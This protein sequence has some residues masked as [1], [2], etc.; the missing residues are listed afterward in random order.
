MK[1]LHSDSLWFTDA[2]YGRITDDTFTNMKARASLMDDISALLIPGETTLRDRVTEKHRLYASNVEKAVA[3]VYG[4]REGIFTILCADASSR[5]RTLGDDF[6]S[7]LELLN[8]VLESWG[9]ARVAQFGFGR[10]EFG[11]GYRFTSTVEGLTIHEAYMVKADPTMLDRLPKKP[12]KR[13]KAPLVPLVPLAAGM[14]TFGTL[15]FNDTRP[16]SVPQE[17]PVVLAHS[18]ELAKVLFPA[19]NNILLGFEEAERLSRRLVNLDRYDV[20]VQSTHDHLRGTPAVRKVDVCVGMVLAYDAARQGT[21]GV[22]FD[23]QFRRVV[24]I[25]PMGTVMVE[26]LYKAYIDGAGHPRRVKPSLVDVQNVWCRRSERERNGEKTKVIQ[27]KH[28]RRFHVFDE[29]HGL[30]DGLIAAQ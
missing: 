8:H 23:W 28:W 25:T 10:R 19:V 18:H 1:D 26:A 22:L 2:T 20:R 30:Y 17:C 4:A 14:S 5:I 7:H 6:E 21:L 24:R 29:A 15:F 11:F 27:M 13:K 12:R 16:A 3:F 9:F